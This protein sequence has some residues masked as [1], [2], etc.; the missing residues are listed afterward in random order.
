MPKVGIQGVGK[1]ILYIGC[2]GLLVHHPSY[3]VAIQIR[4]VRWNAS[5]SSLNKLTNEYLNVGKIGLQA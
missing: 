2:S 1:C 5:V 3:P 4:R